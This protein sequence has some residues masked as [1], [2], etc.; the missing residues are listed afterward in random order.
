MYRAVFN[1]AHGRFVLNDMMV[2]AGFFRSSYVEGDAHGTSYQEG[3][4][5]LVLDIMHILK[6]QDQ[7]DF[8]QKSADMQEDFNKEFTEKRS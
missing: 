6:M 4:R 5:S 2:N 8:Y 3:R 1:S 7:E